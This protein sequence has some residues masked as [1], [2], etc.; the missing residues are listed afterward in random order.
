MKLLMLLTTAIISSSAFATAGTHDCTGLDSIGNLIGNTKSFGNGAI[1]IA[2]VSTEEPAAAPDHVLVFI[3]DKEAGYSCTAISRDSEGNGFG[4]VD[5][6]TL[7]SISYD[8]KLGLLLS[9]QVAQPDFSGDGKR[10]METLK[11]RV[12]QATGKV[13]LE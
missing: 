6:T 13:T 8:A 10:V 4:S 9:I 1:R 3:Y 5:M 7:K 2:W 12:N 11:F